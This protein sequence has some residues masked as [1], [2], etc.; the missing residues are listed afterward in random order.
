[1]NRDINDM[2]V[3][4]FNW[5]EHYTQ[6]LEDQVRDLQKQLEQTEAENKFLRYEIEL[7]KKN[8]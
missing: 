7:L 6:T 2:E 3:E 1:M 8:N 5:E 4:N